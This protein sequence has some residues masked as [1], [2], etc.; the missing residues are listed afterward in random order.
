MHSSPGSPARPELRQRRTTRALAV[1][2]TSAIVAGFAGGQARAIPP[3]P[4][5]PPLD[6][7]DIPFQAPPGGFQWQLDPR[8]GDKIT[9]PDDAPSPAIVNYHYCSPDRPNTNCDFNDDQQSDGSASFYKY[10]P[11]YVH[12]TTLH[13]RFYGCPTADEQ[14]SNGDTAL[15]YTWDVIDKT[16][17]QPVAAG[18]T[19][20]H[21][22]YWETDLPH[23]PGDGDGL[24][25][26][27]RPP[28]DHRERAVQ[29]PSA[30]E[31]VHPG[32]DGA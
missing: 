19:P 7:A 20:R 27:R 3:N 15:V 6:D 29:H 24:S 5:D 11:G 26:H 31:P 2:I 16:T 13:A 9:S 17:G 8:F 28:D 21:S 25:E 22:C 1:L 12:P 14:N 18:S 4:I 23:R 10:D 32:R 30:D